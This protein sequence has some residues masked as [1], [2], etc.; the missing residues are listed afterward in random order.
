MES[1]KCVILV[2]HDLGVQFLYYKNNAD[3][4]TEKV[5]TLDI[6]SKKSTPTLLG[7]WID[8]NPKKFTVIYPVEEDSQ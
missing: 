7:T 8:L 5:L 3:R 1:F 2:T 6:G 4:S